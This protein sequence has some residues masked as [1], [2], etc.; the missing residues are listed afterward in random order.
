MTQSHLMRAGKCHWP[1]LGHRGP[2]T[3]KG[4]RM[5]SPTSMAAR[6]P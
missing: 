6:S 5:A 4:I 2:G 1:V 3:A